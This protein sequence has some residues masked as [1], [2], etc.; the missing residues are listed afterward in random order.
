MCVCFACLCMHAYVC[1]D[2]GLLG[3]EVG[4]GPFLYNLEKEHSPFKSRL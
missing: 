4:R 2:G 1:V 3:L